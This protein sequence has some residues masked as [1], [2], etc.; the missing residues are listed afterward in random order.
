MVQ[1]CGEGEPRGRE[2]IASIDRL[3]A[4]WQALSHDELAA[5]LAPDFERLDHASFE[6]QDRESFLAQR[7]ALFGR[8]ERVQWVGPLYDEQG[9]GIPVVEDGVAVECNN[10]NI[11]A[12]V[13]YDWHVTSR[14]G[15]ETQEHDVVDVYEVDAA[16]LIRR[17]I[18]YADLDKA[19]TWR[20]RCCR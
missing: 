9:R 13:R 8:L 6:T 3:F 11:R 15:N 5:S 17:N 19:R 10:G 20:D 18:D 2:A 16:G 1:S 14:L 7:E 4:A 12:V